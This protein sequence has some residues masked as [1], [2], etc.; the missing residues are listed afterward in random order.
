MYYACLSFQGNTVW[1]KEQIKL[2]A[3]ITSP[4]KVACVGMNYKDHCEEI[5]APIPTEPIFFS[6]FPSSIIGPEDDIPYPDITEVF[7][8]GKIVIE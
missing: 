8:P 2:L 1:E 4:D 7:A 6:K 5:G 3:P